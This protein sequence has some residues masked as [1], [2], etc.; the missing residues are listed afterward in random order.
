M[1]FVEALVELRELLEDGGDVE[2][3][4]ASVAADYDL[5]PHALRNRAVKAWGDLTRIAVIAAASSACA[6]QAPALHAERVAHV[7][8]QNRAFVE[9]LCDFARDHPHYANTLVEVAKRMR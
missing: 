2:K 3:A 6:K 7:H 8:Q 4:I 5:P 1:N 9:A